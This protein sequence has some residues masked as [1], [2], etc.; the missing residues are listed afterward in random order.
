[1]NRGRG[2]RRSAF[3]ILGGADGGRGAADD[4]AVMEPADQEYR[5]GSERLALGLRAQVRGE[6]HLAHVELQPPDHP[7]ERLNDDRYLFE[8]ERV[9]PRVTVPSLIASVAPW[10]SV[11]VLSVR[12]AMTADDRRAGGSCRGPGSPARLRA[13]DLRT[14]RM[15]AD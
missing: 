11:T 15:S 3:E 2:R 13:C 1:M 14:A 12:S 6:G 7:A 10:V 4:S 8:L 5:Q 9:P